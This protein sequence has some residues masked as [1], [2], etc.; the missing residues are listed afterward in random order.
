MVIHD[1]IFLAFE[2]TPLGG[3]IGMAPVIGP[4]VREKI[5]SIAPL[6]VH[7]LIP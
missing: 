5:T 1:H 4:K 6:S 3:G 2:L 7:F